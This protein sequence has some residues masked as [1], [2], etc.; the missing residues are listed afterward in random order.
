M[1]FRSMTAE[2]IEPNWRDLELK[3]ERATTVDQFLKDHFD[4]LNLCRK[5][6]ML[7]DLRFV[8]MMSKLMSVA[9]IFCDN[10]VRFRDQLHM[11]RANWQK[12]LLESPHQMEAPKMSEDVLAFLKRIE[13]HWEKRLSTFKDIV[14]LLSTT[15]NPSALPLSYRLQSA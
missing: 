4:F 5:E 12:D 9:I 10:R 15:D 3:M 13:G 8:E 7:T 14:A 6:C 2:V 1:L 11:E